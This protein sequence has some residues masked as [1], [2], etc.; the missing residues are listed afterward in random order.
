[1]LVITMI[2]L[3]G[4]EEEEKSL[5][6]LIVTEKENSPTNPRISLERQSSQP[7]NI[8]KSSSQLTLVESPS[9]HTPS[10]LFPSLTTV[11]TFV[12]SGFDSIKNTVNNRLWDESAFKKLG[13][14]LADKE[15]KKELKTTQKIYKRLEEY[16]STH[17]MYDKF[18]EDD[19]AVE[20]REYYCQRVWEALPHHP[21][22]IN[23]A[24]FCMENHQ[25]AMVYRLKRFKVFL[26]IAQKKSKNTAENV[27][28]RLAKVILSYK[29]ELDEPEKDVKK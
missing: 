25:F 23:L 14:P 2:P 21:E 3:I 5:I 4:M 26:E 28:E 19:K 9:V 17:I 27:E 29:A 16:F 7:L 11:T 24:L 6:P 10:S 8:V 12:A 20:R 13:W 22:A 15:A 1:M 18:D